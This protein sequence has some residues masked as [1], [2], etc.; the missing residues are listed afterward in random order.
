MNAWRLHGSIPHTLLPGEENVWE[1]VLKWESVELPPLPLGYAR[2]RLHASALNRR[3]LWI[4]LGLYPNIKYPAIL[5][6]DG[7]GTVVE[8]QGRWE[9]KMGERVLINPSLNWGSDERVQSANY[10][11]LGM[12]TPG[13]FAEYVDVPI[14]NLH[15]VPSHLSDEE[16]A[17]IPL[18][19]LTA[20]RATFVQ[21]RLEAS[22]RV[23]V[24]G[25]GGG[26]AVWVLQLAVAAG[27][28]VWV[29]SSS[30]NKIEKAQQLGAKGGVLY[31]QPDWAEALARLAG[32]FDLIVDGVG[33]QFF[34]VYQNLI[35]PGGRIV[36]YGATQGNPPSIDL[37][38]LFWKQIHLIGSTMGSPANFS[39]LLQFIEEKQIRPFV[40]TVLPL[41]ALPAA[42]TLLWSG[43]QMGK[44]VL[45]H[46]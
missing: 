6:S 38:R 11:I 27:A 29:T 37:R 5:G 40:E 24:P 33:G 20:Y 3:D 36:V 41:S 31:T 14:Q 23:L 13:T 39:A 22:Q 32:S 1:T 44:V 16:A 25:I 34:P 12:P 28:E 9:G 7:C 10:E 35:A 46:F 18:A 21:G 15:P 42:L 43:N 45:Q 30:L 2:I 19:G 17:A 4:G 8:V 26:V